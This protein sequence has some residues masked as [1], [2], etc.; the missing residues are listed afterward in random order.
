MKGKNKKIQRRGFTLIESLVFLFIFSLISV[1]FFQAYFV[2]VRTIIESKNRLGATALANQKMEVI[3]SIEYASIGTKHWNGSAWVYGIPAGDLIEEEAVSV[4]TIQYQVDTFVQYVDDTFDGSTPTDTI[5]T[6]Y[7]RV[8][9]TVSWG[10]EG[11][12]QQVAL[13]GNF[14]PN[15][16]ESSS[17]GGVLSI[18]ILDSSGNGVGGVD[19]R[20]QK[21]SSSIDTTPTTDSTG[22]V[23]LPGAPAGTEA[24][25]LTVSKS[26]YFGAVTYPAYPTSAYNPVDVHASVV[27][28][29]LNQKTVVIDRDVDILF[30][31]Q[32]PFD[33]DVPS[34]SFSVVGGRVLG[35]N[36]STS[37]AVYNFSQ[38]TAT[39]TNG[40]KDFNDQ[41]HGQYT[42]TVPDTAAYEFWKITPSGTTNTRY[43]A[44]PGTS[45]EVKA[46]MLNKAISSFQP[47]VVRN[48]DNTVIAGATVRISNT[49]LGYDETVT[50][51]T[52]GTGYFPKT[53]TPLTAG[54][55]DVEIQASGFQTKTDTVVVG[56]VLSKQTFDLIAN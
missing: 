9:V 13:F 11:T 50:M 47:K 17:G 8:R 37:L 46:I 26:G 27:A 34:I 7:K 24:Y 43:D 1:A 10:A 3:R 33:V 21:S 54:T 40:E 20:I 29:V 56:S 36:P 41:S 42:F 18:N 15:G 49:T 12:D 28:A 4:N 53:S 48:S 52:F 45:T 30:R 2:T 5:P 25:T 22:N 38:S 39:D 23:T 32:D 44:L 14:S 31:T 51:D 35:T 6:D 19:V 16:I 55:Y